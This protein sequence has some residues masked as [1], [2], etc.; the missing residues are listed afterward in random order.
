MA[1]A[2]EKG[3]F[4]PR[5]ILFESKL[6]L[7]PTRD[8]VPYR[9]R[10]PRIERDEAFTC[11][12]DKRPVRPAVI[13]R[14]VGQAG[15]IGDTRH[16]RRDRQRDEIIP[17]HRRVIVARRRRIEPDIRRIPV[18]DVEDF[19]DGREDGGDTDGAS[20]KALSYVI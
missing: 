2:R 15:K 16:R 8:G 19:A 6:S 13:E 4:R 12:G 18:Y 7:H 9:L 11:M 14:R 17:R 3:H 5:Y 10:R 1:K 20:R